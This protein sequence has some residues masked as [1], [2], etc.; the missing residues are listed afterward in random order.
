MQNQLKLTPARQS[1]ITYQKFIAR[2]RCN[3][4]TF[5]RTGVAATRA[6]R[7]PTSTRQVSPTSKDPLVARNWISSLW[8]NSITNSSLINNWRR[9]Q[10]ITTI[11]RLL[12]IVTRS[13]IW[14]HSTALNS[15][16]WIVAT[17][18]VDQIEACWALTRLH[19]R[20]EVMRRISV[21]LA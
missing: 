3:T 9:R 14:C 15:S 17:A 6:P 4:S 2:A 10:D 8:C 20:S 5:S 13:I 11:K 21:I 18:V 16:L 12:I 19:R 1:V 7:S